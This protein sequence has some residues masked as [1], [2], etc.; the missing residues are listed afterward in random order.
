MRAYC[1]PYVAGT[2]FRLSAREYVCG[3]I[4][5][6]EKKPIYIDI[7]EE[8][9]KALAIHDNSMEI[10]TVL[11]VLGRLS[12]PAAFPQTICQFDSLR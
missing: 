2:K 7:K 1:R 3:R 9:G 4:K 11:S 5:A 6:T 10:A 12:I 8:W